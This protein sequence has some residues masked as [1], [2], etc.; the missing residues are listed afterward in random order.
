MQTGGKHG[1]DSA[2][3]VTRVSMGTPELTEDLF[4]LANEAVA[5][6]M[7]CIMVLVV[8]TVTCLTSETKGFVTAG[9]LLGTEVVLVSTGE[10][11]N[12]LAAVSPTA[13]GT[14]ESLI[15][16][17]AELSSELLDELH[18]FVICCVF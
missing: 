15:D 16:A 1:G 10:T 12:G 17:Q 7:L 3:V 14:A 5:T 13:F 9:L 11:I 4:C 6:V 8:L 18:T 2:E